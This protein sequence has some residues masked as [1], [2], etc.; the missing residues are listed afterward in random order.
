MLAERAQ[1]FNDVVQIN[2]MLKKQPLGSELRQ[3]VVK[4]LKFEGPASPMDLPT[5]PE[6][7]SEPPP[8]DEELK[9]AQFKMYEDFAAKFKMEIDGIAES[10]QD[11]R[12]ERA[13]ATANLV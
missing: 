3:C 7:G 5:P 6:D 11:F 8:V 12:S 2:R 13:K 9:A 10:L 1:V 4:R